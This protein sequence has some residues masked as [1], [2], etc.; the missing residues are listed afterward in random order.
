LEVSARLGISLPEEEKKRWLLKCGMCVKRWMMYKVQTKI[1]SVNFSHAVFS[2]LSTFR[3]AGLGLAVHGLFQSDLLWCS[4]A[5]QF[6]C[7]LKM[8]SHV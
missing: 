4:P 7:E 1:V 8:T 2:L 5:W 3:D 6:T